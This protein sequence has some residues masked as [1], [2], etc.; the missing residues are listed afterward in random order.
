MYCISSV[1]EYIIMEVSQNV[2]IFSYSVTLAYNG[3]YIKIY[4]K[5]TALKCIFSDTWSGSIFSDTS[6]MINCFTINKN[7]TAITKGK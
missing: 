1:I 5:T 4:F 6:S 7:S 3:I 2:P